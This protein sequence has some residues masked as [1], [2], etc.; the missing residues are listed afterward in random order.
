MLIDK[1][2]LLLGKKFGRLSLL[3]IIEGMTD[4]NR[5]TYTFRLVCDCG[6]QKIFSP[7]RLSGV[8]SGNVVSCGCY[9][10]EKW[11]KSYYAWKRDWQEKGNK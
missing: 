10:K 1:Y 11:R 8:L 9:N 3:E 6:T 4:K 2:N 5:K 7:S